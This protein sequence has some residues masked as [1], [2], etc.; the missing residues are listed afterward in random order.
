MHNALEYPDGVILPPLDDS[1]PFADG[2]D[3]DGA[4]PNCERCLSSMEPVKS[5][6]GERWQC[7]QCGAVRLS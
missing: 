4:T 7:P 6:R 5:A 3:L 2:G 1:I